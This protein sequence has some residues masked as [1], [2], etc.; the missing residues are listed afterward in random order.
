[1]WAIAN[2]I[3]FG[4]PPRRID[5]ANI[6]MLA[7]RWALEHAGGDAGFDRLSGDEGFNVSSELGKILSTSGGRVPLHRTVDNRLR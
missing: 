5:K 7:L 6:G 3:A 1:V 4:A 2:V